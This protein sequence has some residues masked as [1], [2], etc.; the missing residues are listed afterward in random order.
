MNLKRQP[1][2][3]RFWQDRICKIEEKLNSFSANFSTI[4]KLSFNTQLCTEQL[5]D[6]GKGLA[7]GICGDGYEEVQAVFVTKTKRHGRAAALKVSNFLH[8]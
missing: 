3:T 8:F 4:T 7:T 5:F 6:D 2:L 1:K